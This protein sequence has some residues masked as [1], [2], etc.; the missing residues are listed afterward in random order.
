MKAYLYTSLLL[1]IFV[2][3]VP[4]KTT[5]GAGADIAAPAEQQ[6]L[7][8]VLEELTAQVHKNGRY[9][10]VKGAIKNISLSTL[11]GFVTVYL[12]D[13]NGGVIAAKDESIGNGMEFG[14]GIVAKFEVTLRV[15]QGK[16]IESVSVDFTKE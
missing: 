1:G 10:E 13:G 11:R 14:Q 12:L 9:V 8:T 3:F 7:L 6:S 2:F 4:A 5:L 16:K 15:P